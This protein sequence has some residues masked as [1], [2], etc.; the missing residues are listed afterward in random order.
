M[1]PWGAVINARFLLP[2]VKAIKGVMPYACIGADV[3]VGFPGET[4]DDFMDAFEFIKSLPVSYLHVFPFSGKDL[5][6]KPL[7]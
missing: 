7:I 5:I 1:Q 2:R 4:D 3:I 6:P